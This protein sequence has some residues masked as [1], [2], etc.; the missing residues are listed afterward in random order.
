MDFFLLFALQTLFFNCS[1][2]KTV[3]ILL[4]EFHGGVHRIPVDTSKVCSEK[5]V[6]FQ[7]LLREGK[8]ASLL[9][10]TDMNSFGVAMVV[11]GIKKARIKMFEE[12]TNRGRGFDVGMCT[13][14][15]LL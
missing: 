14:S 6:E 13:E 8:E 1:K 15:L 12:R 7:T 4:V 9:S 5:V 3:G 10:G 2:R 11:D